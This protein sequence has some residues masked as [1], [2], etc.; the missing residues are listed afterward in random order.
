[1]MRK[2]QQEEEI[3]KSHE[4]MLGSNWRRGGK[5]NEELYVVEGEGKK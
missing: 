3:R 1:M 5:A 4:W 2:W